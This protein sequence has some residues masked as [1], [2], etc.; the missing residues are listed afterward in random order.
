MKRLTASAKGMGYT[1]PDVYTDV[2]KFSAEWQ[3]QPVAS[4]PLPP[5][6]GFRRELVGGKSP[7]YVRH[8]I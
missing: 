1:P 8:R 3:G 2:L 6:M 4:S 5:G 7:D